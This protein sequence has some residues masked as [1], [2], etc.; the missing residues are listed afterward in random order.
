MKLQKDTLATQIK[1]A[2]LD[3]II[4]GTYKPGERLVELPIAKELGVSQAPVREAFQVLE[5]MR[6]VESQPNRG[7]RVRE[8]SDCEMSQS[9]IVRG[10]LEEAAARRC[11]PQI[12]DRIEDLRAEVRGMM[13]A[14]TVHNLDAVAQHNVNFHRL[15]VHACNNSVLIETWEGLAFEAKWRILGERA[16]NS[17]I[18]RGIQSCEPIIEAFQNGDAILAGQLLRKQTQSCAEVQA[19]ASIRLSAA[20]FQKALVEELAK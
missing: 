12:Q 8:I 1:D 10:V 18:L 15:I 16:A 4:K 9:T 17:V 6:F 19:T 11:L 2:L 5:A 7:T 14:M 3:R 13:A 20:E